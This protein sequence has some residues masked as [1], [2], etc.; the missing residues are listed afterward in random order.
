MLELHAITKCFR[1]VEALANVTYQF[2]SGFLYAIVGPNGCGKTTLLNVVNGFYRPDSGHVLFAGHSVNRKSVIARARMGMGRLFQESRSF[3]NLQVRQCLALAGMSKGS[4]LLFGPG[5]R[6][7]Q[8]TQHGQRI[9]A[10][11][12]LGNLGHHAD[13]LVGE[14]SFGQRRILDLLCTMVRS[15]TVCYLLDEPFAGVDPTTI[16]VLKRLIRGLLHDDGRIVIVVS[17]EM[18]IVRDLADELVVMDSGR[19]I[20]HGDVETVLRQRLFRE[21]YL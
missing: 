9:E 20:V 16:D 19:I 2:R 6:R 13:G 18:N 5:L 15:S 21:V 8:D 1:G 7:P 11:I 4:D 14:L 12:A 10:L 3:Q 17:H